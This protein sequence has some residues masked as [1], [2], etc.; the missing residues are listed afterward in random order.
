[1]NPSHD[2][3]E[4]MQA[5]LLGRPV[6]AAVQADPLRPL[7]A[8]MLTGRSLNQGVLTATLGLPPADFEALWQSY[9]PGDA[10][11]LHIIKRRGPP[12]EQPLILPARPARL[13]ALLAQAGTVWQGVGNALGCLASAA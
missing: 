10:L 1:M 12:L 4:Q 13:A 3:R 2:C 7:L 5:E 11:Q 6:C 8:S 9:F